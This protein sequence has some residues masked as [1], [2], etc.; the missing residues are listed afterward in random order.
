MK[1]NVSQWRVLVLGVLLICC[2]T[3]IGFF[4]NDKLNIGRIDKFQYSTLP[5][6]MRYDSLQQA[7]DS[8][9]QESHR[10]ARD[11]QL[12][13]QKADSLQVVSQLQINRRNQYAKFFENRLDSLRTHGTYADALAEL[14]AAE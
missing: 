6:F 13:K 7:Y 12:W 5:L 9:R 14:G 3:G 8:L 2:G 11:A 4:V 10:Y 1:N